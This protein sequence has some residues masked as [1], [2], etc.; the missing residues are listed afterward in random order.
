MTAL[1]PGD[2]VLLPRNSHKSAMSALIMSASETRLHAARGG[3]RAAHRPCR[4]ARDRRARRSTQH[5]EAQGRLYDE[6]YVLRFGRRPSRRSN[7]SSHARGKLLLVDEAWGPHLHFHPELPPSATSAER[8]R[9]RQLHP[10]AGRGHEPVR[11]AAHGR[12]PHRPRPAAQHAAHLSEHEPPAR[13]AGV[14]RCRAHADGHARAKALLTHALALARD[15]R[16]RLNA[17]PGIFCMGPSTS[18]EPGIAAYDETRLVI[19]VKD[20]GYT[21]YQAAEASC[22]CATD[23]QIELAD[24]FNVVALVTFGDRTS[25]LDRLVDAVAAARAD[26]RTAAMIGVAGGRSRARGSNVA[27][28]EIIATIPEHGRHTAG[29]LSRRPRRNSISRIA[30]AR[31]LRGGGDAVSP[32]NPIIVPGRTNN[33]RNDRLSPASNLQQGSTSK[34][35]STRSCERSR[36]AIQASMR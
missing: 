2:A 34:A 28:Y 1:R 12:R 8:R 17:I 21:G 23:V 11:D 26:E 29:G 31:S 25:R 20:L 35:R 10:Q 5:P 15:A 9:V 36:A 3:P 19:T 4:H 27:A 22:A 18:G 24:L 16:A 33:A 30:Q 7:G 6:P 14:A 13:H 32:G